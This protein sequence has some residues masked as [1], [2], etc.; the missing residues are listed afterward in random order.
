MLVTGVMPW[1]QT[2]SKA[3]DWIKEEH[4]TLSEAEKQKRA[5]FG[6]S[7]PRYKT[8]KSEEEEEEDAG[9][10]DMLEKMYAKHL[11]AHKP[12]SEERRRR[13]SSSVSSCTLTY[14]SH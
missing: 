7:W 3:K 4:D 8:D 6:R 11:G 13:R 2:L 12:T 14:H 1:H 5:S 9:P 10:S